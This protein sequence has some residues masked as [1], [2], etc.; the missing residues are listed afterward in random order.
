MVATSYDRQLHLPPQGS[1]P[2][3]FSF[4]VPIFCSNPVAAVSGTLGAI[5]RAANFDQ[6]ALVEIPD[7]L[8]AA[9]LEPIAAAFSD[10]ALCV[11]A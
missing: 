6:L 3:I 11:A 8:T 5:Y 10:R 4:E 1:L 9:E 7:G 2:D